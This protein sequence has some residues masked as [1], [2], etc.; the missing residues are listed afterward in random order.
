MVYY[1]VRMGSGLTGYVN[2]LSPPVPGGIRGV[3]A[4]Q[5]VT[6]I[7]LGIPSLVWWRSGGLVW[8]LD[9]IYLPPQPPRPEK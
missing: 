7:S 6:K 2:F 1:L 8:G 5:P 4:P 3:R 9:N